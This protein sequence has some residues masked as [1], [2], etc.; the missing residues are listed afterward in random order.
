MMSLPVVASCSDIELISLLKQKTVVK[1]LKSFSQLR[2]NLVFYKR[3][4]MA[5]NIVVEL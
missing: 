3:N 5:S 4:D 2:I 1:C